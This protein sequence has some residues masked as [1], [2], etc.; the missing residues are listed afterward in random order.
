MSVRRCVL[1]D[2]DGTIIVDRGYLSDPEGLELIEGAGPALARL[3]AR[4]LALLVISNQSGIGRGF[5]DE[6][7]L[8]RIHARLAELLAP[9]GATLDGIYWCPHVPGDLCSCRKPETDLVDRAVAE[10]GFDPR[11]SFVVGDKACDV[12]LGRRI[13]ATTILVRTGYGEEAAEDA[14]VQPDYVVSALPDAADLIASLV[15]A[16]EVAPAPAGRGKP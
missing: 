6:S 1:L 15:D 10:H 5:L 4:G 13:G 2:R 9:Y 7:D 11:E 12:E 3:R 14:S 16:G 8:E